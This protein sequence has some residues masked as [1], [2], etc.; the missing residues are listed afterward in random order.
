[1]KIKMMVHKY[2]DFYAIDG[3][4]LD[5]YRNIHPKNIDINSMEEDIDYIEKLFD[6]F[7]PSI[8]TLDFASIDI[9]S[10]R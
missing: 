9:K 10:A 8:I 7:D 2:N 6:I 3:E 1:M 5:E 4:N